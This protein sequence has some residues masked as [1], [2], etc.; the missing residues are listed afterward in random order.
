[1][2]NVQSG[3]GPKLLLGW[4]GAESWAVEQGSGGFCCVAGARVGRDAQVLTGAAAQ[5][6]RPPRVYESSRQP[7]M[8]TAQAVGVLLCT[9]RSTAVYGDVC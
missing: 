2:C 3:D 4:V 7:L 1:M 8:A 5:A 9:R 6:R